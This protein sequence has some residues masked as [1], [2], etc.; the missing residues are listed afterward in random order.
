[1]ESLSSE[2]KSIAI[3][4]LEDILSAIEKLEE[5]TKDIHSVDDFLGSS[6]GMVLLDATCMLLIAIGES[7]KNLDKTTNGVLL[8][9]YPS[10]PWKNV[11]G[12]RDIIAHHYFDVDA[13]QILW[14]ITNEISP[15]KKAIC[16]FIEQLKKS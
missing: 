6:S 15:L 3:D 7:L 5:R 13:S 8:P 10:I 11:K 2:T 14:I 4:I 9:T 1:M 12:L 16:F